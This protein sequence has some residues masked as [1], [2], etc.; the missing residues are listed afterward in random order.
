MSIGNRT[1]SERWHLRHENFAIPRVVQHLRVVNVPVLKRDV[2]TI[3]QRAIPDM[4][5]FVNRDCVPEPT[6]ELRSRQ[7]HRPAA[8]TTHG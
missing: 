3:L 2:N 1:A 8:G 6:N 5:P 7:Q 4:I